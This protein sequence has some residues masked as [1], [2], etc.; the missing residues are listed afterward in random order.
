MYLVVAVAPPAHA[1]L[2]PGTGSMFF[3][4]LIGGLLGAA[5]AVKAFWSRIVGFLGR[6]KSR[7]ERVPEKVD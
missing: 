3:Q 6:R 2:D 4:L 7:G 5:V 1:Y